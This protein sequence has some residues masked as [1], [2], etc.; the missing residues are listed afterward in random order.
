MEIAIIIVFVLIVL[1]IGVPISIS[2][3]IVRLDRLCDEAWSG[4]DVALKRRH[5]L[6]PNLV[7]CV[8]GYMKQ[9]QTVLSQVIALR[10]EAVHAH[11]PQGV[12]AAERAL[13]PALS[14]LFARV[15][16]Y[17]DL[18]SSANFLQLQQELVNTEDRIAAAR[19]FYNNN[20][21]AFNVSIETFPGSMFRGGR[22]EREFFEVEESGVRAPVNVVFTNN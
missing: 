17:P 2:N 7:E 15:E 4:I 14:G 21:R 20:V 6:I 3:N 22:P 1:L 16:A 5:D 19:R 18:K 12:L 13:V 8:K 11:G 10:N 9:E